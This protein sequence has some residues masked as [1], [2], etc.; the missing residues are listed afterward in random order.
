MQGTQAQLNFLP[1][2]HTDFIFTMFSEEMGFI[3]AAVLLALST[4]SCLCSLPIWRS[5]AAAPSRGW[6]RA[7]WGSASS[8]MCSSTWRW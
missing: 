4:F 3:G 7:A 8:L 1:E 5:D 2:K 6:S